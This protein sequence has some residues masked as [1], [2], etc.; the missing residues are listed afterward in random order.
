M[1]EQNS[2]NPLAATGDSDIT[3][4]GSN[5]GFISGLHLEGHPAI[6][7]L[8]NMTMARQVAIMLGLALSVAI[9]IAVV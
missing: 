9:G 8:A 1:S 4:S 3:T 2:T 7:G 5:G 6:R